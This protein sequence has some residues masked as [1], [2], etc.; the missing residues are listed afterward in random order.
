M[1]IFETVVVLTF[2][3]VCATDAAA[4]DKSYA[5]L[6]IKKIKA[7]SDQEIADQIFKYDALGRYADGAVAP[8]GRET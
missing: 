5:G 2:A 6:H 1:N 7:L 8:A 3:L 4:A